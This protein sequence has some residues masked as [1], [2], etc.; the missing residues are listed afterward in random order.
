M[1][2][3]GQPAARWRRFVDERP[4]ASILLVGVI[5]TQLGTYFGYVFP[6]V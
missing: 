3:P 6:A 5:A 1:A 4:I 2:S